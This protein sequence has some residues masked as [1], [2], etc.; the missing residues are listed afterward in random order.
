MDGKGY[1]KGLKGTEIP[2]FSRIIHIADAYHSMTSNST[3]RD[4]LNIDDTVKELKIN[5]GTQ[6][7]A[8]IARVFVEKVL[9][10]NWN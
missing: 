2:L 5:S 1:P 3:Y 7:E 8:H 10:Q 4:T 6:F 9:G